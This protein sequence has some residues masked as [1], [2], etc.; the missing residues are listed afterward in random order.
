[1][2]VFVSIFLDELISSCFHL[3]L[4]TSTIPDEES[5]CTL[6]DL[7]RRIIYS[8]TIDEVVEMRIS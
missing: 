5:V 3:C 4:C 7:I 6:Y 1:M 2:V 8:D